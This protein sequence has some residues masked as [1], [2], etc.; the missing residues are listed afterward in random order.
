[1]NKFSLFIII[2]LIGCEAKIMAGNLSGHYEGGISRLG[3]IQIIRF[4]ILEQNGNLSGTFDD[5][6]DA[7]FNAPFF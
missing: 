7:I 4:D 3:S 1:M 5:P 2:F 6:A